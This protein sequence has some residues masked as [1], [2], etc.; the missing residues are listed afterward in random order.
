MT[1]GQVSKATAAGDT[2]KT[3]ID[4]IQ[5]PQG[6]KRI[7]GI[8][9]YSCGG[10]GMTTLENQSGILE[11]ESVDIALVPMQFPLDIISTLTSGS[12]SLKPTIIP[13][14]IPVKGQE[15]ISGYITMDMAITVAN[16][17]RFGIITEE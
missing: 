7:I 2:V 11:L 9:A 3:L 17:A 13:V 8:W 15:K 5:L 14:N 6:A 10:P 4:T 1:H 16:L 12:I